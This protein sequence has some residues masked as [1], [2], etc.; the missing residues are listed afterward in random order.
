M[1]QVV[2]NYAD[3][4]QTGYAS[5]L[6]TLSTTTTS[7]TMSKF[8]VHSSTQ[9]SR[10]RQKFSFASPSNADCLKETPASAKP[11]PTRHKH[12]L[13]N[14]AVFAPS[15]E[16]FMFSMTRV[17]PALDV[18][19]Q[20]VR[21]KQLLP[22]YRFHWLPG[23]SKCNSRD[24]AIHAFNTVSCYQVA[25]FLGPVCDYSLAPVA[26]YAPY[27]N[28]PVI[29]PGGFAHQLGIEKMAG[30]EGAEYPYLTRIGYTFNSMAL[31]FLNILTYFRWNRVKILYR[32]TDCS[33]IVP[34]F[35][36]LNAGALGFYLEKER[37]RK[38]DLHRMLKDDSDY[39]RMLTEQ[40]GSQ[41]A[42]KSS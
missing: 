2:V 13:L 10:E 31:T 17:R 18:A 25:L 22:G 30:P 24:A 42:G 35:C 15:N 5:A 29:S 8:I 6:T 20:T 36:H 33:N 16:N 32:S 21:R 39:S 28:V 3:V 7:T 41:Y 37:R 9:Q 4:W 12:A 40:L 38:F 11:L 23:D 26:R 1:Q 27:W 14:V 34:T 19:E